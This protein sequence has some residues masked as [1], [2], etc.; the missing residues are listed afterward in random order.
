M[1]GQ[2]SGIQGP[3]WTNVVF[4]EPAIPRQITHV[5]LP[6]MEEESVGGSDEE[7][8]I[9]SAISFEVNLLVMAAR[10]KG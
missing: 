4:P 3:T 7:L 5:G 8:A 1:M 2:Q 9:A 6:S 10:G